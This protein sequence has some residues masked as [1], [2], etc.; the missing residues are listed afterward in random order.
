MNTDNISTITTQINDSLSSSSTL[1]SYNINTNTTYNIMQDDDLIQLIK[2]N[3]SEDEMEIFKLNFKIYLAN[4]NNKN[5]FVINLYD[6]YSYAGFKRKD[7]AKALLINKFKI[8][9][10]YKIYSAHNF[11]L[12]QAQE[13]TLELCKSNICKNTLQG[14]HNKEIIMLSVD[15]FKKFCIK[16]S[17]DESEKFLDYYILIENIIFNYVK[18]KMNEQ[19][20]LNLEN[21]KI[22]ASKDKIIEEQSL[23]LKNIKNQK[24]EEIDKSEYIYVFSTDKDNIYKCGKT[25]EP[26]KRKDQLQTA[27]VD[28]IVE[29]YKYETSNNNILESIIHYIL[30]N[31]RCHSN[32]EHFRCN[33]NYIKLIINTSGIFLDT[34]KSSYEHITIKE[35]L[36]KLSNKL[37]DTIT[38]NKI[39]NITIP[40]Q[41]ITPEKKS[42]D[43][44]NLTI[45]KL[46][47]SL[48]IYNNSFNIYSWILKIYTITE[49]NK[50]IVK[51]KEIYEI[52]KNTKY[53]NNL[54]SL[55]KRKS[56]YKFFI[57]ELQNCKHL[58]DYVKQCNQVHV[59]TNFKKLESI[60]KMI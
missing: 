19:L 5:G 49:N 15:T 40:D 24:Y 44:N 16:A 60:V 28:D 31:Y 32:R 50:D 38:I 12:L 56:N 25:K 23:E 30:Q 51:I 26:K 36:D 11:L 41:I 21:K 48:Q 18:I 37:Q 27:C 4:E 29:L 59:I 45:T 7:N 2:Q 1:I 13:Q 54:T 39:T 3:F 20:Q 9:K 33:L 53:Y 46:E 52:F 17:T 55:Q 57:E 43:K 42:I 6:I 8:D 10:H 34:L 14:G 58:K 35:L 22:S 47:N